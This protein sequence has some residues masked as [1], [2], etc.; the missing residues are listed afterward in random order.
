[1]LNQSVVLTQY[2]KCC[3]Y[4]IKEVKFD[5]S[6][7]ST[8][9]Y[10]DR[11]AKEKKQISYAEYYKKMYGITIED[12]TQPLLEHYDKK[13]RRSIYLIPELCKMTGLSDD[14]RKNFRLMKEMATVT[15][16]AADKRMEDIKTLFKMINQSE[17]CK[18]LMD[19]WN[20]KID[21]TPL[22]VN[23]FKMNVGNFVMAKNGNGGARNEFAAEGNPKADN[24]IQTRMYE[25]AKLK[26][27]AILYNRNDKKFAN[28]F[29]SVFKEACRAYQF[30]VGP[31]KILQLD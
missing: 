28:Q 30:E 3:T 8:F 21:E 25:Q 11:E 29:L 2:N 5:M 19:S 31:P 23:G 18:E 14:Q 27:W 20:V 1:M 26:T 13:Q 12:E 15:H 16:K 24:Q 9:E 7:E 4:T 17:R 22:D 10:F 6:P